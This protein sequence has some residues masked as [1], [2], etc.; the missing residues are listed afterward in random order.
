MSTD[1]YKIAYERATS[2]IAGINAQIERLTRRKELLQ[3][4]LEPL[5]PLLEESA[6]A[7]TPAMP[8][9]GSHAESRIPEA[10]AQ[11][12][13]AHTNETNLNTNGNGRSIPHEEIAW[14]AFSFWNERGQVHGYHEDDWFRAEHALHEAPY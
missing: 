12:S 2:E 13:P 7:T 6:S 9:D 10:P 4:L 11:A 14:L 8:S 3:K 1:P 5:Q